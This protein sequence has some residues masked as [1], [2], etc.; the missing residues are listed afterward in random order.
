MLETA[1]PMVDVAMYTIKH[2]NRL[3]I[4][5]VSE[6][7]K[8]DFFRIVMEYSKS[9]GNLVAFYIE[10]ITTRLLDL[11]EDDEFNVDNF[12]TYHLSLPIGI[13]GQSS[14]LSNLIEQDTPLTSNLS[15][16]SKNVRSRQLQRINVGDPKNTI[17]QQT[18][19][20]DEGVHPELGT[21][22]I[23]SSKIS[24]VNLE[25][26][27]AAEE[28]SKEKLDCPGSPW[29][30]NKGL[31]KPPKNLKAK[32][33][34]LHNK[35]RKQYSVADAWA[36]GNIAKYHRKLSGRRSADFKFL[37]PCLECSTCCFP[38]KESFIPIGEKSY[39]NVCANTDV[40]L[41]GDFISAYASL[42]CH[43]NHCSS[44]TVPINSGKDVP[45][46][47]HVTFPNSVMT[48][49]DYKALPSSVKRIV[50][51]MDT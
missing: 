26:S 50:S 1:V 25:M 33:P 17:P 9:N 35:S 11:I 34:I 12:M 24:P 22:V 42:V 16:L 39:T 44:P 18:Y 8:S 14:P 21:A 30:S 38:Y 2:I 5:H 36:E 43:N 13:P 23:N 3:F 31:Y 41:D 49:K 4:S 47:S 7:V 27:F 20:D 51:V 48:I 46:L 45:Q 10:P 28:E 29:A 32:V 37:F 40:W 15:E 6:K 19:F